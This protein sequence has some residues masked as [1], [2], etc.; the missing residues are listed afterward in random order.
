M[1]P[2][3]FDHVYAG[4]A[5]T[6]IISVLFKGTASERRGIPP[7]R[8]PSLCSCCP[9]SLLQHYPQYANI[10]GSPSP[11]PHKHTKSPT[12]AELKWEDLKIGNTAGSLKRKQDGRMRGKAPA[13][14]N[15]RSCP[16]DQ[17]IYRTQLEQ[18]LPHWHESFIS[19][20]LT[21]RCFN[22]SVEQDPVV[23]DSEIFSK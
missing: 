15:S 8:Y 11:T 5:C 23:D 16:F 21:W 19:V 12:L 13:V 7:P 14:K 20:G 18:N 1:L 9:H 6:Y 17:A 2:G 22:V 4:P 10:S 3:I